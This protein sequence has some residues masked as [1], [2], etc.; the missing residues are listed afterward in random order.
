MRF[1][2][3]LEGEGMSFDV[4]EMIEIALRDVEQEIEEL[5]GDIRGILEEISRLWDQ[6]AE[7]RRRLEYLEIDVWKMKRA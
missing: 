2:R 4:E 7:I 1:M 6:V 3:D 5:R